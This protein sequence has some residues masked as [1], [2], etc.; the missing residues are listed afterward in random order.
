MVTKSL[1]NQTLRDIENIY[2]D[3]AGYVVS[4]GEFKQL[5]RKA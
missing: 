2:I 3:V 1:F 4:Y 5:C